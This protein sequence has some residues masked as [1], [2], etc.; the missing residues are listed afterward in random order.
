MSG[1]WENGEHQ[2]PT[3]VF[4][5]KSKGLPW[6]WINF[7]LFISISF[8]LIA[9][10]C[11]HY[12]Y[13]SHIK[14]IGDIMPRK[15]AVVLGAGVNKDG[16][17][18][19]ALMDRLKT[20][21]ELYRYGLAQYLLISGDDGAY[22]ANEVDAMRKALVDLGVPD[23]HIFTDSRGYRTYESCRRALNDFHL[24]EAIIVTQRFHLPRALFLCGELGMDVVGVSADKQTYK[25]QSSFEFR[26]FFASVKAF[27][28]IYIRAPRPP[29]SYTE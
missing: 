9:F 14:K 23:D 6:R 7:F 22:H 5:P 17:P 28:D 12:A 26:E 10:F 13:I 25:K 19:D 1:I 16:S 8:I 3:G 11:V 24:P 2:L 15:V 4:T 18:S 20:G 27:I 21:A 29:V